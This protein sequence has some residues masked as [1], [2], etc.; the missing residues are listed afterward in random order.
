[1]TLPWPP[2]NLLAVIVTGVAAFLLGGIWYTAL[3][4]KLWIKLHGYTKEQVDA[5]QKARPPHIFF[6]TML[7]AYWLMATLMGFLMYWIK[8]TNWMDGAIVGLTVW[9]IVQAIALTTYISGD[10]RF[11]V[12]VLDGAYQLCFLVMTGII[13]AVWQ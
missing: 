10:K 12:Y 5:M 6:G 3:F 11:G 7:L 13:L 4:G 1:M 2:L 9:G 8:A